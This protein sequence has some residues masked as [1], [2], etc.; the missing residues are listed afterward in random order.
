VIALASRQADTAFF[1]ATAVFRHSEHPEL[2]YYRYDGHFTRAGH[3][4]YAGAVASTVF[5]AHLGG[6]LRS[7]LKFDAGFGDIVVAISGSEVGG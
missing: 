4:L 6:M 5:K 7:M 2:L 3:R 1:S